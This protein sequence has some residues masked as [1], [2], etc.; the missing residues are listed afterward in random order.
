MQQVVSLSGKRI[1]V[2][3]ASDFMGP[4]LCTMFENCG[5]LVIPDTSDVSAGDAP[6]QAIAAVGDVDALVLNLGVPA[7]RTPAT[8]V[9]DDEWRHVFAHMVDPLP[10][11]MRAVLPRMIARQHG[12]VLLMG[13]AA[14]FRGMPLTAT[15][16]AARAAQIGFIQ[17]V[18]VEV[19]KHRVQ[20]NAIAQNFVANPTYYPPEIQQNPKFQER[21]KRDVPLG[22]LVSA[23][24]DASFAA[25][26]LSDAADCF[27]GQIFPVCGGWVA[28]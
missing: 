16:S 26:L 2:T 23:D 8:E 6:A 7:P 3:Q 17:S 14:A 27:V 28:R 10:R 11:Y 13:S 22:R 15:Y 12:K 20:V 1:L 4:A 18:G 21:L 25:Y 19:A 5:A 24:E 9:A